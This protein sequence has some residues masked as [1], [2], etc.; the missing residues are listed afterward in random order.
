MSRFI[1]AK[2]ESDSGSDLE[3]DPEA[4]SKSG[5][6]LIAKLESNYNSK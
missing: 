2:L 6:E 3:S 4:G 5:T 1:T